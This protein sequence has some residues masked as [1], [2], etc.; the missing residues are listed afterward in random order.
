MTR[1]LHSSWFMAFILVGC[2]IPLVWLGVDYISGQAG[3]NPAQAFEV[4]TGRIAIG[5][6]TI[7]LSVTPLA[8]LSKRPIILRARRPLGLMTFAYV[9]LHLLVLVGLDYGFNVSL[10]I[11]SYVDKPFIW[12]GVVTSLILAILA[13]TSFSWWKQKLG[14]RWEHLHKL[15]YLAAILDLAHYF[16]AVKGNLFSLSGN[17]G[18]PLFFGILILSLLAI[19]LLKHALPS[20]RPV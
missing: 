7:S 16:L 8:W 4:R 1:F 2:L 13:I 17:L 10:L 12:F 11:D 19:R 9:L 14:R 20:N 5:L 15:V 18:R 6:L 3:P